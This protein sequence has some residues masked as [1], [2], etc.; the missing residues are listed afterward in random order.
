MRQVR[1]KRAPDLAVHRVLHGCSCQGLEQHHQDTILK[2][3]P[4]GPPASRRHR[5]RPTAH[6]SLPRPRRGR[7]GRPALQISSAALLSNRRSVISPPSPGIVTPRALPAVLGRE[8]DRPGHPPPPG[9]ARSGEAGSPTWPEVAG[10]PAKVVG[11]RA[12]GADTARPAGDWHGVL[13]VMGID[14]RDSTVPDHGAGVSH[15]ADASS[16]GL[17]TVSPSAAHCRSRGLRGKQR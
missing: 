11:G 12:V 2:F 5:A 14:R 13:R 16:V 17:P 10:R 9:P 15:R 3:S 8:R 4:V 7:S 6:L 1:K